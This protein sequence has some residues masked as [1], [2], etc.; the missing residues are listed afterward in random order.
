MDDILMI[1]CILR[2]ILLLGYLLVDV[3]FLA[4]TG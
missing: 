4:L 1:W 3:R 2:I